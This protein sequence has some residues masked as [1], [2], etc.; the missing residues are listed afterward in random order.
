MTVSISDI[1]K[2]LEVELREPNQSEVAIAST[3][4][5]SAQNLP[6]E[7]FQVARKPVHVTH[8]PPRQKSSTQAD[9]SG[10]AI[11]MVSENV[12]FEPAEVDLDQL[13]KQIHDRLR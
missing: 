3:S 6:L 10:E 1:L 13:E 7:T 5:T 2:L 12:N 9:K 4:F 11:N 8:A